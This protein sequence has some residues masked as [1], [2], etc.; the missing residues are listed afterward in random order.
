MKINITQKNDSDSRRNFV[1]NCLYENII[2]LILPPGCALSEKEIGLQLNVSRTPVREAM[3]QLAKEDLVETVPQI[4]SYVSLINPAL[5]EES[6]F[7]RETLEIAVIKQAAE[8]IN[9]LTLLELE[10][11]LYMQKLMIE[12]GDYKEFVKHDD[13][14]HEIIFKSLGKER[15]W[16]AIDQMNAQFKRVRI[17]RLAST[18]T[19]RW[20][21][22]VEEH[23][24]LFSALKNK[25]AVLAE[26]RMKEHL[27]KGIFHLDELKAKHPDYFEAGL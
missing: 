18:E 27:T 25:D 6:R 3:I 19:S 15:T 13:A 8:K 26:K 12:N 23:E 21:E 2:Q 16:H 14:F 10:K 11:N 9:P 22:V 24:D 1:Y 7:M 5:V 17:L 4:G 20:E